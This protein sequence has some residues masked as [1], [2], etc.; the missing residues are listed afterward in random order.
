MKQCITINLKEAVQQ[1]YQRVFNKL[2][3]TSTKESPR[4]SIFGN[5]DKGYKGEATFK[6]LNSATINSVASAIPITISEDK[7]SCIIPYKDSS[8][9]YPGIGIDF[10]AGE[11]Y[12]VAEIENYYN[13]DSIGGIYDLSGGLGNL[14]YTNL[15]SITTVPSTNISTLQGNLSQLPKTIQRIIFY[16]NINISGDLSI[17]LHYDN[18]D[19]VFIYKP[20]SITYN[21]STIKQLQDK[22]VSV[23]IQD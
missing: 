18:I 3:F 6:I 16:R 22:G 4:L 7:K 2:L 12:V 13:L 11:D 5:I 17:L 10:T 21:N 14:T 23:S 8:I 20:T 9:Q 15:T 19:T 1:N